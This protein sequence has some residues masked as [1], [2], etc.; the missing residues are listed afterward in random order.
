[1]CKINFIDILYLTFLGKKIPVNGLEAY[2]MCTE[3]IFPN[4]HKLLTILCALPISVASAERSFSTLR[5]Y[6]FH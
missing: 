2:T 3:S 6:S 1:M 5:R 4:I